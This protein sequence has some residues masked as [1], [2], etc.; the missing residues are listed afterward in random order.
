MVLSL[1]DNERSDRPTKSVDTVYDSYPLTI[2]WLLCL[3]PN[4]LLRSCNNPRSRSDAHLKTSLI[5]VPTVVIEDTVLRLQVSYKREPRL[6]YA[7]IFTLA[8]L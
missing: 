1:N 2:P 4:L 8:R 5:E 6:N 7:R 3:W